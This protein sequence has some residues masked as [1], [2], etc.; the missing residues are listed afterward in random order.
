MENFSFGWWTKS[1]RSFSKT[2]KRSSS[3]SAY[4]TSSALRTSNTTGVCATSCD[5]LAHFCLVFYDIGCF[6]FPI[7][8]EQLCINF[9]N[10]QLQQFFVRHIFKLEQEEYAREGIDWTRINYQDNQATLDMLAAKSLNMLALIDEE[11]HFPKVWTCL[12][13]PKN[14]S[15]TCLKKRFLYFCLDRVL[16]P[17][18]WIRSIRSMGKVAFT[19]LPRT[20]TRPSLECNTLPELCTMMPQVLLKRRAS[21]Q[22]FF[23]AFIQM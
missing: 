23:P 13:T 4:S 9:A 8:F 5:T 17:P 7:S 14:A 2:Q 10:E 11:S 18:C 20:I 19:F 22:D 3:P 15:L 21:W 12:T 16:I 1:T 6:L